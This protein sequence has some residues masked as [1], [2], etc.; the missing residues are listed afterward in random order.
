MRSQE[1]GVEGRTP[2]SWWD[3]KGVELGSGLHAVSERGSLEAGLPGQEQALQQKS[4]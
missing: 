4:V 1:H 3:W 2:G